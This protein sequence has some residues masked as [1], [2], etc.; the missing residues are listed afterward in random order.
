MWLWDSSCSTRLAS[1]EQ[2]RQVTSILGLTPDYGPQVVQSAQPFLKPSLRGS[3][4]HRFCLHIMFC[5]VLGTRTVDVAMFC[6]SVRSAK[7]PDRVLV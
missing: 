7:G 2:E 5:Y 6:K 1:G 3:Q 4:Y